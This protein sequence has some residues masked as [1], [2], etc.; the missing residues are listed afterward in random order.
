[1]WL[2]V[3]TLCLTLL[4]W[5]SLAF[6]GV[7]VLVRD[8]AQGPDGE[9]FFPEQLVSVGDRAVFFLQPGAGSREPSRDAE[10]WTTDG[11]ASGTE[12]LR[13]LSGQL[14]SLGGNGRIAFFA[15][16]DFPLD[17]NTEIRQVWRTDGTAAGTF[18]LNV[19]NVTPGPQEGQVSSTIYQGSLVFNGCTL[20]GGC[21]LWAS[22]GS[23]AGTRQVRD[24]T[25]GPA[26]SAPH[27]FASAG[28]RLYF[29]ADDATGPALWSTDL[30]T[31]GTQRVATLP[32]FSL[33]YDVIGA[34]DR[35][36]FLEGP[37][38]HFPSSL[39]TSDG[40]AA[41]TRRVP[42]FDHAGGKSPSIVSLLGRLG[43]SLI[44]SGLDR[45]NGF[46]VWKTDGTP[47]GTLRLTSFPRVPFS[48]DVPTLAG[49]ALGSR[50]VFQGPDRHLW[51]TRGTRAS[52]QP[53]TGCTGGCPVANFAAVPAVLDGKL[54]FSSEAPTGEEEP[55][56][57]DGTA[58]GTH[59][60]G[61]LCPP[62]CFSSPQF[63]S[64]LLG[65]MFF[66]E[67]MTLWTTDGTPGGTM[68]LG[69]VGLAG[70][71]AAAGSR[72]VF[73]TYSQNSGPGLGVT[74][75]TAAGTQS[76]DVRLAHG[77]DSNPSFLLPLGNEVR[78]LTCGS[79]PSQLWTSDGTAGGTFALA[80]NVSADCAPLARL[81][82]NAYFIGEDLDLPVPKPQV[83]RSDGTLGGTIEVTPSDR[84]VE[85]LGTAGDRLVIF[86]Q[87]D[88]STGA[89][90]WTSDGTELGTVKVTDL[91][92][93]SPSFL[94][95]SPGGLPGEF[96]F[97]AMDSDGFLTFW[98]SDGTAE[99]T[100]RLVEF[101]SPEEE[102]AF[103]GFTRFN[104]AVY[105]AAGQGG[106]WRTD[107]TIA[108]TQQALQDAVTELVPFAGSLFLFD[109]SAGSLLRSDG[110]DAGT[111][112]IVDLGQGQSFNQ[113]DPQPTAVGGVLY[114]VAFD[115]DHGTELWRT[116]GTR[117]GS[118]IV[119][120]I[121]P[122]PGS[123]LPAGLTAAGGLL[124][125]TANDGEHGRELWVTD[126]TAT[127]TRMVG[128]IAAGPASSSPTNL[129]VAGDHL[130]FSA[131]DGFAGR[132][133]W[134]LPLGPDNL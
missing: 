51:I 25:P 130:F 4:A 81:G 121:A 118:R 77:A 105:F 29:L 63:I 80:D 41:G 124:Y 49:T 68:L 43:D 116:D 88:T 128:D 94:A 109:Q 89:E 108:G 129:T 82:G 6:G 40:T 115:P 95:A 73:A 126:G 120:D 134:L 78:F 26:S 10:L 71:F 52:T 61:T 74:D 97:Q 2:R 47:H 132:E 37:P 104:G 114:F 112:G 106:L 107:G 79:F 133:L 46:Q 21:E 119:V 44:V 17:S 123:S 91:P 56:V 67:G 96:F 57:T 15:R 66:S 122:G 87:S 48:T 110:S 65:Q 9:Q 32:P 30:T 33:T 12:R 93:S 100:R 23:I 1:M 58:A 3:S 28:E 84:T 117:A 20:Q 14:Q 75:G 31:P 69:D 39:W 13:A 60:L 62:P 98:Y 83:L 59:Q 85:G 22:D 19:L 111:N 102:S 127:G 34:G 18:Q 86:I 7:P 76:L 11:T 113:V 35:I 90:L 92:D 5:P 16:F 131:D 125:F 103:T 38:S 99:G 45:A 8:I 64:V 72:A 101:F 54:F 42:P 36:F 70:G 53:L 50:F 27:D 55:W 24:L